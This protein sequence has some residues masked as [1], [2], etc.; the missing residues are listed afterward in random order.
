MKINLAEALK[1]VEDIQKLIGMCGSSTTNGSADHLEEVEKHCDFLLEI[2]SDASE[3]LLDL[4]S[5]LRKEADEKTMDLSTFRVLSE[6]ADRLE[7]IRSEWRLVKV[8]PLEEKE[9]LEP[10]EPGGDR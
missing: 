8:D 4:T 9:N 5:K 2:L 3:S 7:E 10:E 6:T 1:A